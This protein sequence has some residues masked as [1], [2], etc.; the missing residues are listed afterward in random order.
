[1]N[2]AKL[3]SARFVMFGAVFVAGTVA[4]LVLWR[5]LYGL[6]AAFDV[7]ALLFLAS[8]APLL[9]DQV[10]EM[11]RHAKLNDANRAVML[12]ITVT[13]TTVILVAVGAVITQS[14]SVSGAGIMLIMATLVLAWLFA[15]VVYALHYANL[16]YSPGKGRPRDSRG[17]T[18]PGTP[19]P[20]YW[21]F[22]Y[23]AFTLGM[24]FQTS[25][26]EI[27]SR[28]IRR[29]AIG[30]CLAAFVF[31]LGVLAFTINALGS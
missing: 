30:Q 10:D 5:P 25:D 20:D 21:D 3:A 15:N 7:A 8:C 2:M 18:F 1:M 14:D 22:L 23:F 6:M 28:V 24:T 29:V 13:V 31:N 9:N 12:G 16:Y 27:T 11:R 19:E 26:I 17:I 4:A